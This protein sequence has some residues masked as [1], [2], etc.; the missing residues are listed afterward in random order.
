[1]LPPPDW[2]RA[3]DV[4]AEI[5]QRGAS[6]PTTSVTVV[7]PPQADA[8]SATTI[9]RKTRPMGFDRSLLAHCTTSAKVWRLGMDSRAGMEVDAWRAKL[10]ARRA[11]RPRAELNCRPSA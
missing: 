6:G 1:M 4:V 8:A 5:A 11:W 9:P 10:T 2:S 7:P 3:V